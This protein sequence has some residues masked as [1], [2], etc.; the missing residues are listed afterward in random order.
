MTE[1]I[2]CDFTC[3]RQ[4]VVQIGKINLCHECAEEKLEGDSRA[5]QQRFEDLISLDGPIG[6]ELL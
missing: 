5:S 6:D 1:Q 3:G 4:A 2:K